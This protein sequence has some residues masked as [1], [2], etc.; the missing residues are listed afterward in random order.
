MTMNA[1]LS[2]D[3][4][5]LPRAKIARP[6]EP[7]ADVLARLSAR[8]VTKHFDAYGDVDWDHPDHRIEPDDPR[9]ELDASDPLEQT[10]W[11]R[12]LPQSA[13][14]RLGLH[15][16]V[17]RMRTGIQFENVLSGGLLEFALTRPNG[18]PEFR[19]A[20]HEIIEEG[21]HSLMFQE[22]VNRTRLDPK[23]LAG[24]E[25]GLARRVPHLGR[26]FPERFFLHVLA[27]EAP[28][29]HVQRSLLAAERTPHPLLKRIMQ[30]HVT[31]EARHICFASRYLSEHV[32]SLSYVRRAALA[33]AAPFI[34]GGTMMQMMR[35]PSDVVAA[36]AIPRRVVR[37]VH[38]GA[39][40]RE[41][42]VACLRPVTHLCIKL[43]LLG[44]ATGWV[45][46]ALGLAPGH[47]GAS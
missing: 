15:L 47:A 24:I 41:Q 19:Y 13:R 18:S 21:Q 1:L 36:H 37:E 40:Y 14:A 34:V 44:G 8:S 27:G 38:G 23:G 9:F 22:F 30:I 32:P 7:Y 12:A 20:M 2:S 42:V 39:G 10:D 33:I 5:I 17:S 25:L 4:P 6:V 28:I 35:L 11:Y 16:T 31:E 45:W 46:N 29:D 3:L 26:T 43:G